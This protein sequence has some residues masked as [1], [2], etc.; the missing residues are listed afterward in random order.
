MIQWAKIRYAAAAKSFVNRILAIPFRI[1]VY[2]LA[3][4][5]CDKGDK[6]FEFYHAVVCAIL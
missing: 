6:A 3:Y 2:E 4:S 1:F 5:L